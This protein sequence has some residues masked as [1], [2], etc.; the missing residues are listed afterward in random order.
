VPAYN[1]AAN[2]A[3]TVRSLVAS[4]YPG[5]E[6]VVVDDGST[7][8][9]AAVLARYGE[10][11]RVVSKANGGLASARNAGTRAARG[12]YVVMLDA[13]DLC[14]PERVGLQVALLEESRDLVL[15]STAFSA[16]D[17][18]GPVA[19]DFGPAYY[20]M[21]GEIPGGVR[22][23]YPHEKKMP[24]APAGGETV[25]VTVN[26]GD[27]YAPL[28]RG[29]FVHPPTVIFRRELFDKV[30]PFDETLRYTS[31]WAWFLAASRF[32][33]FGYLA[34]PLLDY[35]LSAGQMSGGKNR[36]RSSLENLQ[37]LEG[38]CAKDPALFARE[39]AVLKHYLATFCLDAAEAHADDDA[40]QALRLLK[41]SLSYEGRPNVRTL[42]LLAKALMPERLILGF[43]QMKGRAS[44]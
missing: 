44:G 20:S 18:N 10:R 6:V 29:N 26:H 1:E 39:G 33:P 7:D 30:G 17:E 38:A 15:A 37:I 40:R 24:L 16:F 4:D 19:Q 41:R 23:L 34:R 14:P 35:R 13:D 3:A 2:I 22:A 25:T 43:R 21:I 11:I 5:V 31:D 32:G 28:V 9:T 36:R 27:V 8:D 42:K 12:D